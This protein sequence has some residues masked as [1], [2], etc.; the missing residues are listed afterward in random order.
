M[1][2]RSKT[3]FITLEDFVSLAKEGEAKLKCYQ[4]CEFQSQMQ[5]FCM[6][7]LW[8]CMAKYGEAYICNWS[9]PDF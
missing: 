2:C 9:V 4:P 7:R 5:G 6:L 1:V 8:Q 3:G